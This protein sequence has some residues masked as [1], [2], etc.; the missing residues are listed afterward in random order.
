MENKAIFDEEFIM[1]D[2]QRAQGLPTS[3]AAAYKWQE[4]V[5]GEKSKHYEPVWNWDCSMKLDYDGPLATVS[6]RFYPPTKNYGVGWDGTITL[7]VD[8]RTVEKISMN[9]NTLEDLRSKTESVVNDFAA[10]LKAY[11]NSPL[12]NR[13]P[14]DTETAAAR[15]RNQLTPLY[16][17]AQIILATRD[18]G[19]KL[20][21][22][23][24]IADLAR[25]ALDM[26]H[27]IDATLVELDNIETDNK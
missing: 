5:N 8:N 3:W 13:D 27:S 15:L 18:S 4:E 24:I 7:S 1:T 22:D 20:D 16:S 26:K 9:E 11:V 23:K 2:E 6:S 10:K 19:N 17:L 14:N 21:A 12:Y 25:Q